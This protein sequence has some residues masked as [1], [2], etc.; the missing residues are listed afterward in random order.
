LLF[1]LPNGSKLNQ[2]VELVKLWGAYEEQ[3]PHASL[4]E[5]FRYQLSVNIKEEKNAAPE[6]QLTPDINGQ[7]VILIRKIGKFHIMYSNMALAGT[8]LEQIEEFGILVIIFNKINPIKS[9]VIYDNLLEL[10][11]GTNMLIRLKKRGLISEYADKEDKRVK[12]LKLTAK[13]DEVLK[14]AKVE[15]LRVAG[16][17]VHSLTEYDKQLCIQMLNPIQNKF[18]AIFQKQKNKTFEEVYKENV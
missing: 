7:L 2:T 17:M 6:G 10:S 3:H 8:G 5:F 1:L 14:K 13:G 12:R 9:E 18:S 4:E 11:S 15:V 16:M